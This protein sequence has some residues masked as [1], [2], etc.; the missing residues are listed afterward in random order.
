MNKAVVVIIFLT[1][2]LYVYCQ[3]I[4]ELEEKRKKTMED[5]AYIDRIL[6]DTEKQKNINLNDLTVINNKLLLQNNIIKGLIDEAYLLSE[7]IEINNLAVELM[8]RDL[9]KIKKDYAKAIIN[10]YKEKKG[11]PSLVY[12]L[13]A[14][15]F[16]Q[17]YKRIKYLQQISKFRRNE[18]ETIE[19]LKDE[20][21]KIRNRLK[22]DLMKLNEIK[23]NEEK[24][25]KVLVYEMGKKKR[26]IN[27]LT[28][29]EKQ[30]KE[31]IENKKRIAK[32]IEN[33]ILKLIEEE[34]KKMLTEE[35]TPEMKLISNNFEENKGR[36]PW[37]VE[38]GIIT[39]NFG[40]QKHKELEFVTENNP[41][42]EIT[43]SG[44]TKV[45]SVFNGIVA[46][47]ITIT[48]A[49]MAVIIKHGN[50]YTVYQNLI[51]VK[52]KP[53]EKVGFK[54]ELGEVY[55]DEKNGNKA[56]LKFMIF[57]EREKL[58]PEQWIT[59]EK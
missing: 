22:E 29:N 57:K 54:Q 19:K 31:E 58:D 53:G 48:G 39:A 20:I 3:T 36:L 21:E 30:L 1:V 16:N 2:P 25:K 59:K 23:S 52:V 34:K 7:R 41:G 50:Y 11:Y 8:E 14:R 40:I 44:V 46:K 47:I 5:I 9:G 55:C 28:R 12:I 10:T 4:K 26:I 32:R 27:T 15:D 43:S 42:I 35:I 17:G 24:Q 13:S 45:R 49:N 51:N 6:K 33:E 56:I 38:K 37:P 18:A